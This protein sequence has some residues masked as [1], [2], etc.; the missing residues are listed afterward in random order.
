MVSFRLGHISPPRTAISQ[1]PLFNE[2][3]VS[4]SLLPLLSHEMKSLPW[5]NWSPLSGVG[6]SFLVCPICD[7]TVFL[8]RCRPLAGRERAEPQDCHKGGPHAEIKRKQSSRVTAFDSNGSRGGDIWVLGVAAATC[9]SS[10]VILGSFSLVLP[11][12]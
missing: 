2:R 3:A 4:P 9:M 6:V 1:R 10:R 12:S 8:L 5:R 11:A 7:L